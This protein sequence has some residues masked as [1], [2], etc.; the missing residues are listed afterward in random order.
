MRISFVLLLLA[1]RLNAQ[2]IATQ[3][4]VPGT[5]SSVNTLN[6]TVQVQGPYSGSA[7]SDKPFSGALSLREAVE[8][9]LEYNLGAVGLNTAVRQSQAQ[10]RI[11]RS[12]LLPNLNGSLRENIQQTNLRA[13][14]L[15]ISAP[16]PG[17]S[18][19]SIAGPYN[20]FDL[21][22]TLTQ[23]LADLTAL[24]NYRSAKEVA[25]ANMY[26]AQDARDLVVLAV[27][28]AYLQVIAAQARVESAKVQLDTSKAL[29][30]QTFERRQ[31]GLLA[32]IDVNR[33][34][35]QQ[36]TQQQRLS[37]L[38]NDFAKQKINLARLT[39]LPPNESYQ[40]TDDLPFAAPPAI[41]ETDAIAQALATRADL[42]AAAAQLSSASYQR[43]AAR[44]ERLPS[45]DV[46]ADYGVIGTNPAQSHGT[47]TVVGTLRVPIWQGGRAEGDIA[48]AD[49]ALD[50]RRAEVQDIRGRIESDVRGALLDLQAATSQVELSRNNRQLARQTAELTKQRLD[51]GI[52]DTLEMVQSQEAIA[53]ADLDTITSLFAHNLA[54]LSL[55]RSLGQAAENLDAYLKMQ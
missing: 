7:R 6:T 30:R 27:G 22:A 31:N 21:R 15:R 37:T 26:N 38:E 32:Q 48:Q 3:T 47:F 54:K 24:N 52:A 12:A 35:V 33:S 53:T 34:Q 44:A 8:R 50:Q 2:V 1:W 49:A 5:T 25:R 18:I 42:K 51:A 23:K 14:G 29:Y 28:G 41:S 45:L 9:G 20:Y 39:G 46:A 55:A 16:I 4:P 11:S 13:L 19:P 43:R 10:A 17:F 36:Q 40:L